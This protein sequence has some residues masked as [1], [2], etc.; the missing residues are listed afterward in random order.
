MADTRLLAPFLQTTSPSLSPIWADAPPNKVSSSNLAHPLAAPG[1][2]PLSY[3]CYTSYN[4]PRSLLELALPPFLSV[5]L[6]L[7]EQPLLRPLLSP[8]R[9]RVLPP[10][11]V[12]LVNS[13]FPMRPNWDT[14]TGAWVTCMLS[15]Y[16]LSPAAF[17][18][19]SV[20]PVF[21]AATVTFFG[22]T[23]ACL[24]RSTSSTPLS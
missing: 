1:P 8:D 13:H 10:G 17:L 12:C 19:L 4:H 21:F 14:C 6:A 22:L 23:C 16:F 20:A 18:S 11:S 24:G 9:S 15:P 7:F 2:H 5:R 3:K